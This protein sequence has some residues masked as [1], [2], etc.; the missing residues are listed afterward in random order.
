MGQEF[1]QSTAGMAYC[2][3]IISSNLARTAW[4][5]QAGNFWKVIHSHA[6]QLMLTVCWVSAG[7]AGWKAS[8][9]L[10]HTAAWASSQH[11]HLEYQDFLRGSSGLQSV[12]ANKVE[13]AFIDSEVTQCCFCRS[14]LRVKR[15][16]MRF[17]SLLG[18]DKILEEYVGQEL[19][20][21]TFL[22][23]TTCLS[24]NL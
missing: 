11:G 16:R 21:Q 15:R 5:V 18:N 6:W 9:W 22:E 4:R 13:A 1:R 20:L 2:C 3:S 19:L 17:H 10:L 24:K 7:A 8:R 12:S 23:N 14:P